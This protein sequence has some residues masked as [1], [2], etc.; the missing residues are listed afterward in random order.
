M[1]TDKRFAK[2][3]ATQLDRRR[4]RRRTLF[5]TAV[6]GLI[7]LA[8][9]YARCGSGWGLGG[10]GGGGGT[11]SGTS[12]VARPESGV[13]RCEVRVGP[14][15]ITVDGKPATRDQALEICRHTAGADVVITG[16]ARHGDWADLETALKA[17]KID[18]SVHHHE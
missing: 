18:F 17:A 6:A 11:G 8:V 3:V 12:I 2:D 13:R 9:M 4:T 10:T 7:A 1:T 16:D 15:H 14:G 5:G